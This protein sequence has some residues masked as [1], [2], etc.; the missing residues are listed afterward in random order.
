MKEYAMVRSSS[1]AASKA[2]EK[3]ALCNAL[4]TLHV[5]TITNQFSLMSVI[6]FLML[7]GSEMIVL[8]A[9]NL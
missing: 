4:S 2:R 7:N 1:L 8:I 5:F 3:W 9:H 6:L